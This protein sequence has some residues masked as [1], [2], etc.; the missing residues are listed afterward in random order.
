[1]M[2]G[3]HQAFVYVTRTLGAS[4]QLIKQIED[5]FSSLWDTTMRLLMSL[6]DLKQSFPLTDFTLI[7]Q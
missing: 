5:T 6:G 2:L 3:Q 4:L 1:M 7:L